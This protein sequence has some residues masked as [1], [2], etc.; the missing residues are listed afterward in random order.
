MAQSIFIPK[1][2]SSSDLAALDYFTAENAVFPAG[3]PCIP[4]GL[5]KPPLVSYP[6]SANAEVFFP[7]VMGKDYGG[8]F[9]LVDI[10]WMSPS[11]VGNV[12]WFV[13]WERDNTLPF[14]AN[15]TID[16]YAPAKNVLS[17]APFVTGE[18]QKA[19]VLFTGPE[20]DNIAAGDPYRLSIKRMPGSL[21]DT[22]SSL[23]VIQNKKQY[24]FT[25]SRY[26]F[27]TVL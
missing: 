17:A 21:F 4:L 25:M 27:R 11:I 12:V 20:A 3:T 15:L 14:G 7:A 13:A 18:I 10:F 9:L 5:N 1:I 16:S 23:K 22:I 2:P 24:D 8:N 19:S 26:R 6:D